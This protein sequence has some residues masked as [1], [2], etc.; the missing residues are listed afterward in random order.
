M[1]P[2]L[3]ICLYTIAL[4]L[5]PV[6][7]FAHGGEALSAQSAWQAWSLTPEVSGM[8]A[9]VL[10]V[11]LRGAW[12]RRKS[13]AKGQ[14]RRHIFFLAGVL[15]IF[16]SLQSPI[17]PMGERLFLAHQIQHFLLRM[18][19]PMLIILAYPGGTLIA[20]LPPRLRK[21]VVAPL[22][23]NGR[24]S[25]LIAALTRPWTAFVLFL[26]SLY[27]WQI[28]SV[29]DAALQNT[30]LHYV[31]H[32][33]MLAAG[34]LFFAMVFS[35]RDSAAHQRHGLRVALLSVTIISNIFLGALTTLKTVAL[36]TAYGM[37]QR[38]FGISPLADETGGGFVIWVPSSMMII[39][40]IVL[41]INRWNAA[42]ERRLARRYEWTGSNT[43]ALEF[44]ETAAELRI[45]VARPNRQIAQSLGIGTLAL[46]MLV[47]LMAIQITHQ[48]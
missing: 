18:L 5:M 13:P 41:T 25:G 8:V 4:A 33:T 7:G 15:T 9:L 20:G 48:Y 42:E 2:K 34:L 29:H 10:L 12:R 31:M 28:P 22:L 6:T 32:A 37:D 21:S 36:Y 43:A 46:F 44:P 47:M 23:A 19:A 14:M 26:L 11:Y 40:A 1:P 24:L 27:L 35:R 16:L 38:L 3:S 17:D 39:I 45:K 30:A